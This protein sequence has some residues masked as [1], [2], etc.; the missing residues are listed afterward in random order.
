M[1]NLLD[2]HPAQK[3][4]L[5][6]LSSKVCGM[7]WETP[8][9]ERDVLI[10]VTVLP[11]NVLLFTG[12]GLKF[13]GFVYS[14]HKSPHRFLVTLEAITSFEGHLRNNLRHRYQV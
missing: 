14:F 7:D 5:M 4:F 13:S 10:F 6:S 3:Q 1:K 8:H 9:C 2:F 11:W 12:R